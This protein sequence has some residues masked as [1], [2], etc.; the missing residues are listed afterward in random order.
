MQIANQ[1]WLGLPHLFFL[2]LDNPFFHFHFP[3]ELT[4]RTR[5]L[6]FGRGRSHR[7][8]VYPECSSNH[9]RRKREDRSSELI[10][11]VLSITYHE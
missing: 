2:R 9:G 5:T 3:T 1:S 7:Q 4:I 10:A 6:T 11:Y 8:R